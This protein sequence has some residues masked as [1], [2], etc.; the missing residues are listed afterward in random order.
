MWEPGK[1]P[2]P[3]PALF[4]PKSLSGSQELR[5]LLVGASTPSSLSRGSVSKLFSDSCG[6]GGTFSQF[7]PEFGAFDRDF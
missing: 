5:W 7:D 4:Q 3:F 2:L 6:F 1:C